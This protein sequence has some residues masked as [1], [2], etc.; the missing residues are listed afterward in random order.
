MLVMFTVTIIHSIYQQVSSG[1]FSGLGLVKL[2]SSVDPYSLLQNVTI[3]GAPSMPNTLKVLVGSSCTT[4]SGWSSIISV[5]SI[6][7]NWQFNVNSYWISAC[8]INIPSFIASTMIVTASIT[9]SSIFNITDGLTVSD[10]VTF[11]IIGGQL[12]TSPTSIIN[13]RGT[14]YVDNGAVVVDLKSSNIPIV[15]LEMG[16]GT[17]NTNGLTFSITGTINFIGGIINGPGTIQLLDG[18]QITSA[19]VKI[20]NGLQFIVSAG[21]TIAWPTAGA[22]LVADSGRSI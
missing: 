7:G 19:S 3:L 8:T 11:N 17:M 22:P 15:N 4:T 18:V 9:S 6:T 13:I 14:L 2:D 10:G 16:E 12:I 20:N 1:S 21:H 5:S